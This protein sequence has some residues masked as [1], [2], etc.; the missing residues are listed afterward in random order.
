MHSLFKNRFHA[1]NMLAGRL[2][3]YAGNPDVLVL[4]LPR[5]GVPPAYQ[6][7][8]AL[9]A[10]LDILMVRK[11]GLPAQPEY[12]LGAVAGDG[13]CLLRMEKIRSSA[14]QMSTIQALIDRER[15]EIAR[16][17]RLY[18]AARPALPLEN[19]IIILV[20]DGVATGASMC[21][22]VRAV[23][24]M[25]P[26]KIIVAV[27]VAS[28]ASRK[29]LSRIADETICLH[30]PFPF[31]SVG[32]W[33]EDFQQVGED[34]VIHL[35]EKRRTQVRLASAHIAPHPETSNPERTADYPVVHK[36][37]TSR[38]DTAA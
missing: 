2:A 19:R 35:L 37:L 17:E 6:V 8:R 20:D 13:Q 12:A 10:P 30:A 33:Y 1:G 22:A 24:R 11:L 27:P 36:R 15:A 7:A 14:T 9:G 38:R 16:R 29:A 23:R 5:G 31:R 21:M 26:A 25:Q 4:A 32:E 34:V 28:R 3:A 18:R